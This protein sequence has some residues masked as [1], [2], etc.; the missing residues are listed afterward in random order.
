MF[1]LLAPIISMVVQ[2]TSEPCLHA[3]YISYVMDNGFQLQP[4]PNCLGLKGLLLLLP[5]HLLY[6][7]WPVFRRSTCE[8]KFSFFKHAGEP[9]TII[10]SPFQIVRSFWLFQVHHFLLCT[11][12]YT[13]F[14]DTQQ[15]LGFQKSENNLQFGTEGVLKKKNNKAT[16][17]ITCTNTHTHL[18]HELEMV[19]VSVMNRKKIRPQPVS[20]SKHNAL[21]F[22]LLICF[23]LI[24]Q[25]FCHVIFH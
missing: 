22:G 24:H 8:L 9:C 14:L 23:L 20:N 21:L 12:I 17:V 15:K 19:L 13:L 3:C 2:P 16:R 4:I 5:Q 10:L 11:Q 1:Q 18:F 6:L 7:S 25:I